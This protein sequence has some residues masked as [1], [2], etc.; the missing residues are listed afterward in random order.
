MFMQTTSVG[1]TELASSKTK[2]ADDELVRL[3]TLMYLSI[4]AAICA[5]NIE[6]DKYKGVGK[7]GYSLYS[8]N[9]RIPKNGSRIHFVQDI[10]QI[11]VLV[12]T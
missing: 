8:S 6:R 2:I 10:C 9:P 5:Y 1:V 12:L 7:C 4:I 3:C 11:R